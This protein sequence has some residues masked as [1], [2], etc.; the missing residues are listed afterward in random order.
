MYSEDVKNT[1]MNFPYH[2]ESVYHHKYITLQ[3][4]KM[5]KKLI[6]FCEGVGEGYPLAENSP[7]TITFFKPALTCNPS[8]CVEEEVR[9]VRMQPVPC[10]LCWLCVYW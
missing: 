1:Q 8:S 10:S 4:K 3:P 6:I 5:G 7:K 9:Q 2:T